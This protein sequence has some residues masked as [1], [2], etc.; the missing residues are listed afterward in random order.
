MGE[1]QARNGGR[2]LRSF[3]SLASL[4]IADTSSA[5]AGAD[6]KRSLMVTELGGEDGLSGNFS[7]KFQDL[8]TRNL[9]G[10]RVVEMA[11][12]E[13]GLDGL[14]VFEHPDLPFIQAVEL[15]LLLEGGAVVSIATNLATDQWSLMIDTFAI[16]ANYPKNDP[17]SIFKENIKVELPHGKIEKVEISFDDEG[18]ISEV[19]FATTTGSFAINASE[20]IEGF[21]DIYYV[22]AHDEAVLLFLDPPKLRDVKFGR[23]NMMSRT[24]TNPTSV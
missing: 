22:G 9:V 5:G 1:G 13:T 8:V 10:C 2:S 24:G 21:N 6:S 23:S 14:P 17:H 15:N 19:H 11:F 7:K 4:L 3:A 18:N 12:F 16:P 20:V